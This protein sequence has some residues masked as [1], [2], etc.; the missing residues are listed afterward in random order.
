M[1]DY[2]KGNWSN[3]WDELYKSFLKNKKYKLK[4]TIYYAQSVKL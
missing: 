3:K 1:S 2:K 4:G